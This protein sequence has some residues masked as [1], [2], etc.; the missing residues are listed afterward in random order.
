M[1]ER[2]RSSFTSPLTSVRCLFKGPTDKTATPL[3]PKHPRSIWVACPRLRGEAA[4]PSRP[5]PSYLVALVDAV[6]ELGTG[7]VP[8][9]ADGGGIGGLGLHVARGYGGHCGRA[10]LKEAPQYEQVEAWKALLL[11]P[12]AL[13]LP[14]M[15]I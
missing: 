8:G 6:D 3:L 9:E 14:V 7:W 10:S 5:N 15:L 1:L 4:S 2:A 13:V 12:P 11:T